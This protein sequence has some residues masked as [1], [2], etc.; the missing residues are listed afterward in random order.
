MFLLDR[1]E[2]L[3]RNL[4][5]YADGEL[6]VRDTAH[7]EA[8]LAICD[9]CRSVLNGLRMASAALAGLPAADTPRSFA[10][11][12]EMAD[13][14]S[15]QPAPRSA[16]AYA[17]G[18]RFTAAG[19]AVA[20]A[21]VMVADRSNF[22]G[23]GDSG[24]SQVQGLDGRLSEN[25]G[26][27][28]NESAIDSATASSGQQDAAADVP[29]AT[30]GPEAPSELL[31]GDADT[32]ASAAPEVAG[33]NTDDEN[34]LETE[35]TGKATADEAGSERPAKGDSVDTLTVVEVVLTAFLAA[36]VVALSLTWFAQR[37]RAE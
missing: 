20:L 2:R 36:V 21:V 8:H 18:L 29:V 17:N 15:A 23:E 27:A 30:S 25:F 9:D 37:R 13:S 24:G 10:L 4:S 33:G 12:P 34:V 28:E 3:R 16:P 31:V 22:G 7:A 32:R 6:S 14:P 1:H 26:A 19:L 35:S 5:A 11:S